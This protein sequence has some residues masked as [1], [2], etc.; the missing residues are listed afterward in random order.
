MFNL[1]AFSF[2]RG[3]SSVTLDYLLF[4]RKQSQLWEAMWEGKVASHILLI[5]SRKIIPFRKELRRG[6]KLV[7]SKETKQSSSFKSAGWPQRKAKLIQLHKQAILP[8]IVRCK[9]VKV[10]ALKPA[11]FIGIYYHFNTLRTGS[12]KLFKRPLPGFL[13][14]LTL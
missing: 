11:L 2:K 8:A 1:V 14:I 7:A 13:T 3:I 5:A 6:K 10:A 12:F 9:A 4:K